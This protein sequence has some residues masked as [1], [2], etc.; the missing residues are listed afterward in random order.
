MSRW[1]VTHG[2]SQ[3]S[4]QDLAELKTMAGDGRVRPAD[5]IQPPGA[6][7]HTPARFPRA[8]VVH[9]LALSL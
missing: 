7:A 1:L 5:L 6:S 2:D 9:T 3:F 8:R 4:A